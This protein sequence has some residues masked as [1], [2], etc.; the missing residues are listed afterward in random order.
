IPLERA[1][2]KTVEGDAGTGAGGGDR[3]RS[4][5]E[6]CLSP[7]DLVGRTGKAWLMRNAVGRR[8]VARPH[9]GAEVERG[10]PENIPLVAVDDYGRE[11]D[12][13]LPQRRKL[14]VAD[15]S[16]SFGDGE[17]DGEVPPHRCPRPVSRAERELGDG[18]RPAGG[19]EQQPGLLVAGARPLQGEAGSRVG[20]GDAARRLEA[21]EI[22][23]ER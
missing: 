19:S 9:L 5:G 6:P 8:R 2:G 21:G 17:R 13:E 4:G 16:A 18:R 7:P 3:A 22:A 23:R 20:D 1:E 14:L 15:P 11:L 10:I 12:A